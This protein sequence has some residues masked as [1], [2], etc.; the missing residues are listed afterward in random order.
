MSRTVTSAAINIRTYLNRVAAV[1]ACVCAVSALLYGVFLL[2]AVAHAAAQTAAERH[3][4]QINQTLGD[5]E[6]Q[7]LSES[8]GLSKE[9]AFALGYVQPTTVTTVFATVAVAALS[10]RGQ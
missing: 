4:T 7:Y 3:L 6:A 10:L 5:L 2:E 9:R 8:Q 1:F